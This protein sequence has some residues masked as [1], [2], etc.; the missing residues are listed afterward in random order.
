MLKWILLFS[1]VSP[2]F[3]ATRKP[4]PAEEQRALDTLERK[5]NRFH[6]TTDDADNKFGMMRIAV[7]AGDKIGAERLAEEITELIKTSRRQF[8]GV[9]NW[10]TNSKKNRMDFRRM[11]YN[12]YRNTN[13]DFAAYLAFRHN[14]RHNSGAPMDVLMAS[15]RGMRFGTQLEQPPS[16]SLKTARIDDQTLRRTDSLLVMMTNGGLIRGSFEGALDDS[17][18]LRE[19]LP[20][21]MGTRNRGGHYRMF[22]VKDIARMDIVRLP[23]TI[24]PGDNPLATVDMNGNYSLFQVRAEYTTRVEFRPGDVELLSLVK[25]KRF[26]QANFKIRSKGVDPVAEKRPPYTEIF[27][28]DCDLYLRTPST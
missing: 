27:F 28:L 10:Y 9:E 15:L 8:N 16:G 26:D 17:Y 6:D 7:Q 11:K 25:A 22:D 13:P 19:V 4:D 24:N 14:N 23:P 1:L 18:I 12:V 5:F 2:A 20:G 3:A 21:A